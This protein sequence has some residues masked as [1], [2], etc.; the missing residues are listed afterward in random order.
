M[1]VMEEPAHHEDGRMSSCRHEECGDIA[2]SSPRSC[3]SACLSCADVTTVVPEGEWDISSQDAS[4]DDEVSSCPE[5]IDTI[6]QHLEDMNAAS[7]EVNAA[8]KELATQQNH[9]QALVRLWAVRSAR[10]ARTVH[11]SSLGKA[12]LQH[13]QERY[14]KA[15][16]EAIEAVSARFSSATD[17]GAPP[18]EL[19]RLSKEHA[20]CLARYMEAQRQPARVC[21]RGSTT[22]SRAAA[23][24]L[25]DEEEHR[26][27]LSRIDEAIEHIERRLGAA[28]LRYQGA[29]LGLES[30]SEDIHRRRADS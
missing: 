23:A 6:N 18:S 8:Q 29:L 10:L 9:R 14:R 11:A 25:A 17:A 21:A 30:L 24:H 2:A 13:E 12:K 5:E 27:E 4:S 16:K 3:C 28:K 1:V 15:T 20:A 22:G 19:A 26:E 7:V